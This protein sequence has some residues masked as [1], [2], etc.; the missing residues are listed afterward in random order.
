MAKTSLS[1]EQALERVLRHLVQRLREVGG[2][3]LLGVAVFGLP[4]SQRAGAKIREINVLVVLADASLPALAPLAAVLTAAQRQSQVAALLATPADLRAEAALFP[5]RLLDIRRSHR[6]LH[7][8]VHLDRLT[9]APHG[10]R[11]AALQE[12]RSLESRMRQRV[13]HHGTDP[14]LLWTGLLQGASRLLAIL[15]TVVLAAHPTAPAERPALLRLAAAELAVEEDRLQ[16][17]AALRPATGRPPDE[18]VREALDDFL[19]LL[20]D[21]GRHLGRAVAAGGLPPSLEEDWEA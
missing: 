4:P 20:A 10:L 7:G 13:V 14:D 6:V 5:A 18:G 1:P 2:E 12:I 19:R 9:I 15:E 8:E 16:P 11:F 17:L 21:L 3:N